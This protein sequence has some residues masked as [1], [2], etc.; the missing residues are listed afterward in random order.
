[1]TQSHWPKLRLEFRY[2]SDLTGDPKYWN[3]VKSAETELVALSDE[4]NKSISERK[5][6]LL[7][8]GKKYSYPSVL[9]QL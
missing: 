5:D 6:E 3:L 8:K 9:C 7:I 2:L 1:M 4:K